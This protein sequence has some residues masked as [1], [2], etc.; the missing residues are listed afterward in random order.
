MWLTS[1]S[2]ITRYDGYHFLVNC[3]AVPGIGKMFTS[4][5]TMPLM[6][7]LSISFNFSRTT[8]EITK[9][10]SEHFIYTHTYIPQIIWNFYNMACQSLGR[11]ETQ[12]CVFTCVCIVS[13]NPGLSQAIMDCLKQSWIVSS[14]HGLYQ[15][16]GKAITPVIWLNIKYAVCSRLPGR[17]YRGQLIITRHQIEV[18]G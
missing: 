14:N 15:A 7:F 13:S 4:H 18:L 17:P 1:K 3:Y 2:G 12:A 8:C 6:Q 10:C 16:I 11:K 9:L 5:C